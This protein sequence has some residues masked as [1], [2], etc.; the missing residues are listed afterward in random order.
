[1]REGDAGAPVLLG[2]QRL[3][4]LTAAGAVH[5]D[6]VVVACVEEE[7]GGGSGVGSSRASLASIGGFPAG[8]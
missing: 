2:V 5:L 6:R 4:Q 1:M 7:D 3:D 8:E